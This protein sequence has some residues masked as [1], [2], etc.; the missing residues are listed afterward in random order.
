MVNNMCAVTAYGILWVCGFTGDM[1]TP[2]RFSRPTQCKA[3]T[4]T[5]M[6]S[7]QEDSDGL[8]KEKSLTT[9]G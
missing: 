5:C 2:L 8:I 4:L 6:L 3:V 7:N 1:C 9:R